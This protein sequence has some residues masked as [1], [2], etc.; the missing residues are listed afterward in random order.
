MRALQEVNPLYLAGGA[1]GGGTPEGEEPP[2]V[3]ASD[4]AQCRCVKTRK[5]KK[6]QIKTEETQKR[7]SSAPL[8]AAGCVEFTSPGPQETH[9]LPLVFYGSV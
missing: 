7:D 8:F 2:R 4:A 6:N 5:E 1:G 3:G 9:S